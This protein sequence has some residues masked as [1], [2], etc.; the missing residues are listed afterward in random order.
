[1]STVSCELFSKSYWDD[2]NKSRIEE[3]RRYYW[4]ADGNVECKDKYENR[5]Y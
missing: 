5:V 2:I 3:G 4:R 1:M